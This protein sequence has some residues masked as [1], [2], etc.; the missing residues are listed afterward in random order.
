M[1]ATL[2]FLG[3]ASEVGRVGVL[4]EGVTIISLVFALLYKIL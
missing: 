2:T 4:L 3:G 1:E